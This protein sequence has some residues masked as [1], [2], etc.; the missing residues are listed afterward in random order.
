MELVLRG[1]M[2][3]ILPLIVIVLTIFFTAPF[4]LT[5]EYFESPQ[6]KQSQEQPQ[7]P[8]EKEEEEEE[9]Y[10][11]FDNRH[12]VKRPPIDGSNIQDYDG[13]FHSYEK[14]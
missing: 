10:E 3:W 13:N 7:E 11:T 14:I 6:Q 8:Q 12:V 4:F 1:H 5:K 9:M 2:C